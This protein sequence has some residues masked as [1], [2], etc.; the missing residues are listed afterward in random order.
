MKDSCSDVKLHNHS[1]NI[2]QVP[3]KDYKSMLYISGV[4]FL[5]QLTGTAAVKSKN[6][7]LQLVDQHKTMTRRGVVQLFSQPHPHRLPL[8][9]FSHPHPPKVTRE[10]L[11]SQVGIP[12]YFEGINKCLIEKVT[13]PK[14]PDIS[15]LHVTMLKRIKKKIWRNRI[16]V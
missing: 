2:E 8:T 3:D 5:S 7:Y 14:R 4:F 1:L 6:V 13:K 16:S 10:I 15:L 12:C 11:N 9:S